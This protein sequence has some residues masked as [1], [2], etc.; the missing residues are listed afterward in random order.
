MINLIFVKKK[1]DL[2][3]MCENCMLYNK[4]DTIYYVAARKMF[5]YGIKL[6]SRVRYNKL[7]QILNY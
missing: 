3:L 4:M 5:D 1:D 6:L 7:T 2:I